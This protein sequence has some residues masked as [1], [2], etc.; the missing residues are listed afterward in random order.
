MTVGTIQALLGRHVTKNLDQSTDTKILTTPTT[1]HLLATLLLDHTE[2]IDLNDLI[3]QKDPSVPTGQIDTGL[4]VLAVLV[5]R[6]ETDLEAEK[7]E[8]V[9][10]VGDIGIGHV[11][12][13]GRAGGSVS[14]GHVIQNLVSPDHVTPSLKALVL[15]NGSLMSL[16][17]RTE[18]TR[19][20]LVT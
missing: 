13:T 6:T 7:V 4:A 3:G 14:L 19:V 5:D 17:G 18:L 11:M 12:E 2:G 16:T 9:T 15:E 8:E 1:K 10:R 20:M